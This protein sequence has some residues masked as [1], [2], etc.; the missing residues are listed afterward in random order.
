MSYTIYNIPAAAAE[1]SKKGILKT[2]KFVALFL[3]AI[4][5]RDNIEVANIWPEKDNILPW[6]DM[7]VGWIMVWDDV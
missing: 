7:I 1:Q 4:R 6:P 2:I 5:K 3:E